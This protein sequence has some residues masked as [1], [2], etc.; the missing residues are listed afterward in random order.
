MRWR[1]KLFACV[2]ALTIS[3]LGCG[4]DGT[5][6]IGN[7]GA[8]GD[9]AGEGG[10][11]GEGGASGQGGA[12]GDQADPM[13][14]AGQGGA[15][16][17]AGD[18][19]IAGDQA[20]PG[21]DGGMGPEGIP[22]AMDECEELD[23]GFPGDELCIDPPPVGE[24]FQLHIGPAD[25][26]NPDPMFVLEPDDE[27]TDN[28]PAVSG[29]DSNIHFLFRQF[30]MRP[31]A[32]HMI[33][34]SGGS[35][36]GGG[37]EMFGGRRIATANASQDS[38]V[39]GIIAP[40]NQG[41]GIPLGPSSNINVSLHSINVS[42]MPLIRELWVNFWYRD[43]AQVTEEAEQLFATGDVG[44][45][46]APGDDVILGPYS[47]DVQAEGRML[48]FYGHRHANNKRFSAWRVRGSQRDL[49]YEGLHWEETLLL[50]YTSLITNP[51]PN[52]AM[53]VEGGWSGILDLKPGDRLEWECHVV[54]EQDVTL[55]FSNNTYTGEM[56]IMDAELVGT[57]CNSG[58]GLP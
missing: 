32:H 16:G 23:T 27:S 11:G 44:F 15:G 52:A 26:A 54:N 58:F 48:W 38:P 39:G 51:E 36:A 50:E 40:E 3:A 13:S 14:A 9:S 20:P 21:P 33:A 25:Y 43:S 19:P 2:L 42:D 7:G 6:T 37:M 4:D 12:G 31:G 8:A 34:T 41:V 45:S 22:Y 46:V 35:A 1:W 30:R 10:A 53:G 28:F 56:C 17:T 49:F 5:E 18:Q 47:C 24:G 29:N 57:Q 55:R